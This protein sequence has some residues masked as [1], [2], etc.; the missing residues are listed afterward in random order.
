MFLSKAFSMKSINMVLV[1]SV[2]NLAHA[3]HA[4]N[5]SEFANLQ[6]QFKIYNDA[7]DKFEPLDQ[8]IKQYKKDKIQVPNRTQSEYDSACRVWFGKPWNDLTATEKSLHYKDFTDPYSPKTWESLKKHERTAYN[9]NNKYLYC[10]QC[11]KLWELTQNQEF[12][13]GKR[14][15]PEVIEK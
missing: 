14:R 4:S 1:F 5:T 10:G 15:Q 6:A 11:S 7:K 12:L 9:T 2:L 13:E 3:I 8:A